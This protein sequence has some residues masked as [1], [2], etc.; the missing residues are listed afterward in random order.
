MAGEKWKAKDFRFDGLVG[1]GKFGEV[2]KAVHLESGLR[3]AIK[4][5]QKEYLVKNKLVMQLRREVE[6]HSRLDHACIIKFL[7]YFH[8]HDFIYIVMEFADQ[9]TLFNLIKEKKRLDFPAVKKVNFQFS[10]FFL[11]K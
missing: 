1:M 2:Y 7:G 9:G 11:N 5:L 3:V 8:E 10:C 6:I 4:K